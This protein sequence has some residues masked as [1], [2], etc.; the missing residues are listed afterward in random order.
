M[1]FLKLPL[2]ALSLAV[3]LVI[4]NI[5]P[6]PVLSAPLIAQ[7]QTDKSYE[8]IKQ[9]NE[10]IKQG[11]RYLDNQQW[12]Y[13]I[14]VFNQAISI[15][16]SNPNGYLGRANAILSQATEPTSALPL[17]KSAEKDLQT[18]ISLIS[19]TEDPDLYQSAR[20]LLKQTQKIRTM[21]E[22]IK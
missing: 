2:I 22:Q 4:G 8:L 5:N 17:V 16:P 11:I 1:N 14:Y 7:S 21:L 13:A 10:L 3:P 19:P 9:G 6:P 18:A 15:D 20:E 12:D